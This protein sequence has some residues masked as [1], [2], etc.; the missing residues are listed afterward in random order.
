MSDSPTTSTADSP[1]WDGFLRALLEILE[2]HLEPTERSTLLRA[3]GG[4]LAA[5]LPVDAQ[6]SLLGLESR[7]NERLAGARWGS[8]SIELDANGPALVLTHARAPHVALPGGDTNPLGPV[9]EGLHG[10]WIASQPGAEPDLTPTLVSA[11][12]SEVV[13]RYGA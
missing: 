3:I 6:D 2:A 10:A 13:L 1:A 4:R 5:S 11:E 7:M 9:L 12:G 8:V